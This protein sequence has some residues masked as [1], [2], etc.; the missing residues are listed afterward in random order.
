MDQYLL[1]YIKFN[2]SDEQQDSLNE[3]YRVLSSYDYPDIDS[4]ILTFVMM[5]QLEQKEQIRDNVYQSFLEK[6]KDVVNQQG[7]YFNENATLEV[8]TETA[9]ALQ[10]IQNLEDYIPLHLCLSSTDYTEEKLC[11]ILSEYSL[12]REID[13]MNCY[14]ECDPKFIFLLKTFVEN[15]LG[16]EVTPQGEDEKNCII[17]AKRFMQLYPKAIGV[18]LVKDGVIVNQP[19]EL[20]FSFLK[21][22]LQELDEENLAI[23]F[24][25]VV[26][27]SNKYKMPILEMYREY[28]SDIILDTQKSI[29]VERFLS[30]VVSSYSELLKVEHEKNRLS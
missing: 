25:S 5:E 7:I 23:H 22:H 3:C 20:Y 21:D 15:K 4:S 8:Y 19:I 18:Q 14:K 12:L 29:K 24:C 10:L 27:I 28:F 2:F 30:C 1:A 16:Y 17:N 11:S 26:L 6:I 13:I 9:K